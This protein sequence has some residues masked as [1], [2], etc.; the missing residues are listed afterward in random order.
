MKMATPHLDYIINTPVLNHREVVKLIALKSPEEISQTKLPQGYRSKLVHPIT[1]NDSTSF[2]VQ[3]SLSHTCRPLNNEGPWEAVEVAFFP[4]HAP[5]SSVEWET[6]REKYMFP[7]S[8]TLKTSLEG[9]IMYNW[10]P[11]QLVRAFIE[12]HGGEKWN[13]YPED[14]VDIII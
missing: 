1:C 14:R 6:Y 8:R 2:S 3:A 13:S 7:S 11:V 5:L 10:V 4:D 9:I 12:E